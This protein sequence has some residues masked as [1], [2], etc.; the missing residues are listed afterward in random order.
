MNL[1]IQTE[2]NNNKYMKLSIVLHTPI[3][4]ASNQTSNSTY[5]AVDGT[6]D[7]YKLYPNR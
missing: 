1:N 6:D 5:I 3:S 4:N 7:A 2:P